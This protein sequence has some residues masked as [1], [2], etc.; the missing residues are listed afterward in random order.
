MTEKHNSANGTLLDGRYAVA[1][2]PPREGGMSTVSKAYDI[3]TG[4]NCAVKRMK[5]VN[6]SDLR[7]KES[8]N[9]EYNALQAV[10]E[11]PNIV[12]LYDAG[13]DANGSFYLVL[14]WVESNLAQWVNLRGAMT[15]AQFYSP[16][17]RPVLDALVFAQ[18]RG[19]SHRDIKPQNILISEAGSPIISDY[20]IAK[21]LERP[22]LGMTFSSF[23]SVPFTPP[24]DDSGDWQL[25]R[26]CFSWAAVAVFCLTGKIPPDYGSLA[27]LTAGLNAE[28]VPVEILRQALSHSPKERPPLASA[29]LSDIDAWLLSKSGSGS[30]SGICYLA[31]EPD[32]SQ[33]LKRVFDGASITQIEE[34]MCE[35]LSEAVGLRA[36]DPSNV[37]GGGVRIWTVTW[38]FDAYPTHERERLLIRRASKISAAEAERRRDSSLRPNITFSFARKSAASCLQSEL[39]DLLSDLDA[40]ETEVRDTLLSSRRERVFRLWY[41]FLRA[42]ADR[43]ARREN[44]I[45]FVDYRLKGSTLSLLTEL[46]AP[47]DLVGDSRVIRLVSGGHIFCDVVDVTFDQVVV[48]VTSGDRDRIPRRGKLQVNTVAAEK[49]IDR[50]RRALD[51]IN[52]DRAA[53]SHLKNLIVQP[54]LGRPSVPVPVPAVGGGAFDSEK[55]EILVRALGIQDVLAIQGPPGT[56]KTRL[57]EEIIVQYALQNPRHRILL[58]AQTHVALDNVIDRLRARD[59]GMDIVRIGRLDDM[60]IGASSRDL[61]LD[62]KAEAWAKSV[63][64]KAQ[65][66]MASWASARGLDKV[67]IETGMLAERLILL[68]N[69]ARVLRERLKVA[70]G[71]LRKVERQSEDKLAATGSAESPQLEAASVEAEQAAAIFRLELSRINSDM[72]EVRERLSKLGDYG[73]ELASQTEEKELKEW[74]TILLGRGDDLAKCKSLLELQEEWTLR[75]GR[76]M[77]F[78]AAMLA[79][80]QV[81]AGTCIGLA[82]VRGLEQIVYDLCIVD[83]ASKATPTEILVPMSRSRKW[84]LV[85]DPKQLPPFFEDDSV[86]KIEEFDEEE[87]RETILDRVLSSLPD[88]SIAKLLNQYRMVKPIGDLISEV[89]YEGELR[90]PKNRADVVLTGAFPKPVTWIST[91]DALDAREIMV[92][93][94]FR[95]EAE[96]RAIRNALASINFLAETRKQVYDVAL[97]AGYV[98]QVKALQNLIRD[99]LHEWIGLSITC[100]TVDA[101]QG[102]E[103]EICIYSVTRSNKAQKLGFLRERPRLNVALSRGRSVLIIVGDEDFCR[104]ATGDNPFRKV[105]DFIEAHPQ[106]CE[107]RAAK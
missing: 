9:R 75:V 84:I 82:G 15:W 73:R 97:I 6:D 47:F 58:S 33:H 8:F 92:G 100:S 32:V 13:K 98:G 42:K 30:S 59:R 65:S 85:G 44:A 43:E 11:H 87:V 22:A 14:E 64:A 5:Q 93:K 52:Y 40:F 39:D 18:N 46:P 61:V 2:L 54:A 21:Q 24:E 48:N 55:T 51:A 36:I 81:V 49:S 79:S 62:R 41:A 20:G 102:S 17:G 31:F 57:I 94:S 70:D 7:W 25:S 86:T 77:D 90:S 45:S 60:K 96:G 76:S 88:H 53:S 74:S 104:S 23:R 106:Q 50:Q 105:L 89:F 28:T 95:N 16:I 67:N 12:T 103:A 99:S 69:R 72:G 71:A 56:G 38:R 26:D 37:A 63:V 78:H 83:E 34:F 91:S 107:R 19:W 66:H 27:D 29:L 80:A 35:E 3:K 4:L 1:E 10:S 68:L 101:F